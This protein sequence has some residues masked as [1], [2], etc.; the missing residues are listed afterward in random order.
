ML[1]MRYPKQPERSGLRMG[2]IIITKAEEDNKQRRKRSPLLLLGS[3]NYFV[4]VS[5]FRCFVVLLFCCFVAGSLWG[6]KPKQTLSSFLF[7]FISFHS[8][9]RFVSFCFVLFCFVLLFIVLFFVLFCTI[10]ISP[11]NIVFFFF[12]HFEYLYN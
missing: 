11:I 10:P 4:V 8:L 12:L 2:C 1:F 3:V 5:L 7:H 9:F 6:T